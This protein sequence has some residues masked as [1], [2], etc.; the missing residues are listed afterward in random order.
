[1]AQQSQ[2]MGSKNMSQQKTSKA[3]SYAIE[4]IIFLSYMFFSISW[5]AGSKV[6]PQIMEQF[7]LDSL[8]AA[9]TNAITISKIIGNLAAAWFLMKLGPKK[10]V[11]LSGILISA[12]GLGAF[13]T[14]FPMFIVTRFIM[15][16]GGALMVVYFGPIV[17]HYFEPEKR[18][19]LNGINSVANNIGN[20]VALVMVDP[21][22]NTLG[23]WKSVVLVFAGISFL[24]FIAWMIIGEDFE[25]AARASAGESDYGYK[26]GLKDKFNYIFGLAYSGWLT[27][28]IVMLNLFPLNDSIAVNPSLLSTILAVAG[29]V[30]TPFGIMIAKKTKKKLPV[31]RIS[32]VLVP[33][34]G[35]LMV[36]TKSSTVA[37]ISSFALGFFIFLPMTTFIGIPQQLKGT[38]ASRI[39][40]TMA[41]FWSISYIV[42]TVLYT[43]ITN[44]V[45]TAGFQS[46]MFV[47]IGCSLTFLVCGFLL[48]ETGEK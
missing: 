33:L 37:M 15:G 48:P 14:S 5:L 34:I 8:P 6:T 38:T 47:A 31:I 24:I 39:T 19:L 40:V 43:W 20:I 22:I 26:E 28:Y 36:M 32:G 1:M 46:A 45:N 7:N 3:K 27:L 21:I 35:L 12:V 13:A 9:V 17:M 2:N 41:M 11:A 29:V 4:A 18:P 25:V 16:F 42:E 23:S 10:A 44:V 30:A